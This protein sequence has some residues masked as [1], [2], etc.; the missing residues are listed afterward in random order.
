MS[1][2]FG[3][4]SLLLHVYLT[5]ILLCSCKQRLNPEV[6]EDLALVEGALEF[7][8]SIEEV[9]HCARKDTH[10]CRNYARA[11]RAKESILS[12]GPAAMDATLE[13][14]RLNC[15]LSLP[16]RAIRDEPWRRCI[17]GLTALYFFTSPAQDEK[18]LEFFE[19]NPVLLH[20]AV[21]EHDFAWLHNRVHQ[22]RWR[23][24]LDSSRSTGDAGTQR[25]NPFASTQAKVR[26]RIELL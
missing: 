26:Y 10:E 9:S 25:K 19:K 18:V 7:P 17:G 4:A 6:F 14:I 5:G 12:R 13:T 2:R 24:L 1:M 23:K 21:Q 22:E 3:F 20:M 11:V 15:E 16:R 8:G